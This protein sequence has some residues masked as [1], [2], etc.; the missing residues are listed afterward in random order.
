MNLQKAGQNL[1]MNILHRKNGFRLQ[2]R[3][4]FLIFGILIPVL[5]VQA[6]LYNDRL[7]TQRAQEVQVNIEVAGAVAETFRAYTQDI[8]RQESTLG[9]ALR[10]GMQQHHVNEILEES[11]VQYPSIIR[12][13]WVDLNGRIIASSDSS[14]TGVMVDD[15]DYFKKIKKGDKWVISDLFTSRIT[16]KSIFT[17]ARGVQDASGALLG[18]LVAVVNPVQLGE[19]LGFERGKEGFIAITDRE[20]RMV[21]RYPEMEWNEQER[22]WIGKSPLLKEFLDGN[23][24]VSA[25]TPSFDG[26]KYVLAVSPVAQIGWAAVAGRPEEKVMEPVITGIRRDA[27]LFFCVSLGAFFV[28][29]L[30]SRSIAAPVKRLQEHAGAFGR[31]ELEQV[32][33][34]DGPREIKDLAVAFNLMADSIKNRRDRLYKTRDELEN[35]IAE[36]THDLAKSIEALQSEVTERRQVETALQESE[37]KY[38]NL[39]QQYN[40][41]LDGIPDSI[42]VLTP[43]LE[44]IWANRA[45]T[46]ALGKELADIRGQHCHNLW[47]EES[48]PCSSCPVQKSLRTA[49]I[50]SGNVSDAKGRHWE[51]RSVPV[52]DGDDKVMSVIEIAR[53]ITEKRKLEDQL[54]HSL[55]ME[56]IGTL[57]GGIAHDF[58]NILGIILGYT[59]LALLDIEEESGVRE[60]LTH[61]QNAAN[62]AKD[63]VKQILAF[64][65][66]HEQERGPLEIGPIVKEALK[67]LRASIPSTI[68]IMQHID[69]PQGKG[70]ILASPTEVHQILMNLCTN[71]AHAMRERGGTLEIVLASIEMSEQAI[72]LAPKIEPGT[73]VK[74]TV[75]DT[76]QGMNEEILTRIFE[77]YFTTKGQGEGTGLGLSVVHGIVHSCN[78]AIKVNSKP[79]NGTTF[80]VFFPLL[81]AEEVKSEE[82]CSDPLPKGSESILLVDDEHELAATAETMLKRLGYNVTTKTDSYD[83]LE[84]FSS[85]PTLFDLIISDQTMPRLT[86]AEL[87]REAIRLRPD[88]AAILCT[89]YSEIMNEEKAREIGVKGFMMKPLSIIELARTIRRVLDEKNSPESPRSHLADSRR[90]A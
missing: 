15:R 57:S 21:Y 35:S 43:R 18:V 67:M 31:G 70:A 39:S 73:Y 51:L 45:V 61:V 81:K 44:I 53:D 65:R 50:H 63:L 1:D 60:N 20:G 37:R 41:L 5:I 82:K 88:I 75:S 22:E 19:A 36:R 7:K 62:R 42:M 25:M 34:I 8:L 52:R 66:Q 78:G 48:K 13:N 80:E 27:A 3:L 10:S 28:A 2:S 72:E 84:T 76:G 86:G 58:N 40:A 33:K 74:L 46:S 64:S 71:A 29:L 23:G 89:G 24:T 90:P 49:D 47:R 56:A 77:P 16:G 26:R 4:L 38:R 17:V 14:A 59:E 68:S 55:K 79:G 83:A 32:I 11:K 54:R 12:I 69:L 85:N 87:A 9:V 6:I 30:I